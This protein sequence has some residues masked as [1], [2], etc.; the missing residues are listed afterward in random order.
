MRRI[1]DPAT[2]ILATLGEEGPLDYQG[3]R[4]RTGLDGLEVVQAVEALE[5]EGRIRTDRV[6]QETV[7]LRSSPRDL[8]AGFSERVVEDDDVRVRDPLLR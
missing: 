4:M 7:W 8:D 5:R 1:G 2:R 6:G 3:L